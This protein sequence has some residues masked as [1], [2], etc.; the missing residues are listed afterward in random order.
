MAIAKHPT[1][2]LLP[3]PV[4]FSHQ[5][6]ATSAIEFGPSDRLTILSLLNIYISVELHEEAIKI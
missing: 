5:T 3:E 1:I 4:A 2:V 6:I